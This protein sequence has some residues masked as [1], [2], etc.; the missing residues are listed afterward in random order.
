M[1]SRPRLCQTVLDTTDVRGLAEFYRELLGLEYRRGDELPA[2][3]EPDDLEWLVLRDPDGGRA[4][5]FQQTD[6][7]EPTTWP[8]PAVPMQ[9][10]IDMTV[11]DVDSLRA[12]RARAEELGA[13]LVLDRFDDPEEPC[14][15]LADLAGHPFCLFVGPS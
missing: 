6:R 10:H 8:D 1:T 15:V 2:P 3:G 4:L 13:R 14:F 12:A 7:L 11:P 9:L 5:A